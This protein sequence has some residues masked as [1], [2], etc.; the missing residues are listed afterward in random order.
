MNKGNI[1]SKGTKRTPNPNYFTQKVR[2]VEISNIVKS[3][4]QKIYHVTFTK[5]A[6]TK[7]HYHTGGQ[8]LIITKGKGRFEIFKKIGKGKNQFKIKS[9]KKLP[10]KVGDVIYVPA[11]TLHTHGSASKKQIFSHI[12]INSYPSKNQ[13]PKTVWYESDFK[14]RVMKIL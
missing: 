7:I 1:F 2:M 14:Q 5:S 8:V 6:K 13:E 12:A 10:L 3:Q 4:E 11:K 9:V